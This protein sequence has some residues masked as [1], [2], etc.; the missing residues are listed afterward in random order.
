MWKIVVDGQLIGR[1]GLDR[2]AL[3]DAPLLSYAL[4]PAMRGRGYASEAVMVILAWAFGA[5]HVEAIMA[6]IRPANAMSIAVARRVGMTLHSRTD[7]HNL[8]FV[9]HTHK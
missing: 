3:A 9:K 4:A 7:E 8:F 1:A 6:I 5:T 2:S